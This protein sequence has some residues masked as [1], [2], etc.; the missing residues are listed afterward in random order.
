[1]GELEFSVGVALLVGRGVDTADTSADLKKPAH[2]LPMPKIRKPL[3]LQP[4][5]HE[6]ASPSSLAALDL[7][8]QTVEEAIELMTVTLDQAALDGRPSLRVIHGHG[9]GKLKA[10]VR[11]YLSS[12]P[13]GFSFRPGKSDE[14]GDGAT[15]V[16][17]K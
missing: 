2:S 4:I 3:P 15:I 17:L 16:E 9:T 10:A 11:E 5:R 12:S 8:G 14:G 13:Y 7:R 6:R 1:M